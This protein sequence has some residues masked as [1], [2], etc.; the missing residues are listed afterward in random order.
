MDT[1][2]FLKVIQELIREGRVDKINPG[3]G[4][5]RVV[6][7]DKDNMPSGDYK[8]VYRGVSSSKDFYMPRIGEQVVCICTPNASSGNNVGYVI[9]CVYG[10]EDILPDEVAENKR[11][12]THDG[13]M[14][15]TCSG[16]FK[17]MASRI[18]LN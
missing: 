12:L 10:G 2:Y 6:F 18:E 17:V 4:T 1:E 3:N 16:T 15:I 14:Q 5:C 13:D 11:I 7:P 8:I 9:G